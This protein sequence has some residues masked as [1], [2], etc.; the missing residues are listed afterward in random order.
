MLK[1]IK[2]RNFITSNWWNTRKNCEAIGRLIAR[3][4]VIVGFGG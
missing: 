2:I 3:Q 4:V 1:T